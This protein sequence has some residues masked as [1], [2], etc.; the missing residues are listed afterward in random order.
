MLSDVAAPLACPGIQQNAQNFPTPPPLPCRSSELR[1]SRGGVE[2]L[3]VGSE[4]K[5][6][7][8]WVPQ[9]PI[10][11]ISSETGAFCRIPG[12]ARHHTVSMWHRTLLV[13]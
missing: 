11:L 3:S 9:S 13:Y 2:K 6:C 4:K 10:G 5:F 8:F 12:H 1:R 7:A